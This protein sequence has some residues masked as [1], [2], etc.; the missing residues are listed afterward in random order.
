MG[1]LNRLRLAGAACERVFLFCRG[2]LGK[3]NR[4][5][6][7]ASRDWQAAVRR[8]C[9]SLPPLLTRGPLQP[10]Q[11]GS[12]RSDEERAGVPAF[13]LSNT[14]QAGSLQ[15]GMMQ[16]GKLQSDALAILKE[17]AA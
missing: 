2:R 17:A 15:S 4:S 12:L 10:L 16:A 8:S 3:P 9:G 6:I 5:A 14:V 7:A 1:A 13:P 11:V